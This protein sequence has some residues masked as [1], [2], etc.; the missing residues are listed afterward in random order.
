M[1]S[2][3]QYIK[4]QENLLETAKWRKDEAMIVLLTFSVKNAQYFLKIN[5][6]TQKG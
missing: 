1:E 6:G 5:S 4:N 2:L 3:K